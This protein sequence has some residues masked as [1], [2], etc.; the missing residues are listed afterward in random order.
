MKTDTHVEIMD[1]ALDS[2]EDICH[3]RWD[4]HAPPEVVVNL[5]AQAIGKAIAEALAGA[6][7]LGPIEIKMPERKPVEVKFTFT[8]GRI[9]G[10]RLIPS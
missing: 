5:D 10:A 3:R 7:Q 4:N 1:R 9:T 6:I 8:D 2:A